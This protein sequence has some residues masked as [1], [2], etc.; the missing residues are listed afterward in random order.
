M[1]I[2]NFSNAGDVSAGKLPDKYETE[3]KK[4]T[5]VEYLGNV[6]LQVQKAID[7]ATAPLVQSMLRTIIEELGIIVANYDGRGGRSAYGPTSQS[8][9]EDFAEGWIKSFGS[10]VAYVKK[11]EGFPPQ[12]ISMIES[13]VLLQKA[14]I[15]L[16]RFRSRNHFL[17]TMSGPETVAAL[18][19]LQTAMRNPGDYS[20]AQQAL[21]LVEAIKG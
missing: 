10:K 11:L 2:E 4:I 9:Q 12:V 1:S 8:T 18:S 16:G 21:K 7:D 3:P 13:L 6:K 17:E 14:Q 15:F 20:L 5:F 19:S